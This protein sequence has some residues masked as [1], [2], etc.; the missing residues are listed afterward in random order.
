MNDPI[1]YI[2]HLPRSLTRHIHVRVIFEI[3]DWLFF[4]KT[5]INERG[6]ENEPVKSDSSFL[7]TLVFYPVPNILF[8]LKIKLS[9]G[10]AIALCKKRCGMDQE[11]LIM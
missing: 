11:K 8:K 4:Y 3:A 10:H 9:S 1:L 6:H 2:K 5:V 7:F